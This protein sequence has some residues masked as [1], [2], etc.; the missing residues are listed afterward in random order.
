MLVVVLFHFGLPHAQ[1]NAQVK[2]S[3]MPS[4]EDVARMWLESR[5]AKCRAL[6]TDGET[7]FS[8][9]KNRSPIAIGVTEVTDGKL[10]KVVTMPPISETA[11]SSVLRRHLSLAVQAWGIGDIKATI[12]PS[13]EHT[14]NDGCGQ[15]AL[16]QL[17]DL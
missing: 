16:R 17:S 1:T 14:L 8:A 2:R 15:V 12:R 9:R 11:F 7:L 3:T 13:H 10:R 5:S 4:L 6:F